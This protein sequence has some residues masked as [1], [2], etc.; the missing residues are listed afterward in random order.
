MAKGESVEGDFERVRKD[1]SE[2]WLR[3]AYNVIM[4]YDGNPFKVIK[5]ATDITEAK[6]TSIALTEFVEELSQGNF[7]AELDLKGI[8]PRGDA[9][10]MVKSTI[11]LSYNLSRIVQEVN[12][13]VELAGKEGRLGERLAI[14]GV[15]G[16]WKDLADSI[17]QLLASISQPLVAMGR[18]IESL[19]AGD[20]T[21]KYSESAVGDVRKMTDALNNALSNLNSLLLRIKDTSVTI[22]DAS[23]QM[24]DRSV[25]MNT[26]AYSVIEAIQ[27]IASNME[28][29]LK[30]TEESSIL[31]Q[32]VMG[33]AWDTSSKTNFITQSAEKGMRSCESGME[34]IANLVKNM[35]EISSSADSTF[36]SIDALTLRSD[37]ISNT[38]SVITE[39]AA[40][41]NLLALNAAIEA[42][43]AGEAGRGFAV[44][45]EEIR[46]LAEDSKD[47]ANRI[48]R[49]IKDVQKDVSSASITIE[50]M[51]SNVLNGNEATH[52][53]QSVFESIASSSQET[54]NFSKDVLVSADNQQ[55]SISEIVE[56]I[57]KIVAV[58][59]QTSRSTA[60]VLESAEKLNSSVVEI[61]GTTENLVEVATELNTRIS[62]F[63][64]QE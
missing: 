41:T 22:E 57:A 40:Q 52:Q 53:A 15:G 51:K 42:A 56:N 55:K 30:R 64:L 16:S 1:G 3:A 27:A 61:N 35:T 11:S 2:V 8:Q 28:D 13:V 43:R 21:D 59:D 5:Y 12:R 14:E 19:A 45:A 26:T 50:R 47:S 4:D 29:Q 62:Q 36:T 37:E 24:I 38:L 49:V 34:I 54:L 18:V 32:G 63:K 20:L 9:A 46:K 33:A 23:S 10:A 6:V 60:K 58:S 31:V 48:D 25:N 39:I 7:E 17:N 44:V